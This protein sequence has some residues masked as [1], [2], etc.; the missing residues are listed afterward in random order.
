MASRGNFKLWF[1]EVVLGTGNKPC[2]GLTHGLLYDGSSSVYQRLTA[3]RIVA[4][5]P[6]DPYLAGSRWNLAHASAARQC[7]AGNVAKSQKHR[8]YKTC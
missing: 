3:E 8:E 1:L 4:V 6:A 5:L 2:G 7:Q